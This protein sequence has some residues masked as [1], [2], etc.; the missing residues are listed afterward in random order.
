MK[1]IILVKMLLVFSF[2]ILIPSHSINVLAQVITDEEVEQIKKKKEIAEAKKA[3]AEA[4]KAQ[5]DAMFPAPDTSKL[6]G[7]TKINEGTFIETQILGYCAM[8]NAAYE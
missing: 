1:K 8:K 3:I 5:M 7:G 2:L 6:V 4:Q